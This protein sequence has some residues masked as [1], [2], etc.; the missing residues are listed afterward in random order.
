MWR[1]VQAVRGVEERVKCRSKAAVRAT[2]IRNCQCSAAVLRK[3]GFQCFSSQH[4]HD[5]AEL[6]VQTPENADGWNV[7]STVTYTFGLEI[8]KSPSSGHLGSSMATPQIFRQS[9]LKI[10]TL[11]PT[12]LTVETLRFPPSGGASPLPL[13][14]NTLWLSLFPLSG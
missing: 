2:R 12:S 14:I 3:D 10:P 1:V 6:E 13:C 11:T 7:C 9:T 5:E 4:G 8:P